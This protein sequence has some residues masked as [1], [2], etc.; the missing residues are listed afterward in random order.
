[1]NEAT[2]EWV[3]RAEDDYRVAKRESRV[4]EEPSYSAVC[5]HS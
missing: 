3:I 4:E 5:F 2:K 1:M